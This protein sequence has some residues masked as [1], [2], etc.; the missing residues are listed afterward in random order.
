LTLLQKINNRFSGEFYIGFLIWTVSFFMPYLILGKGAYIR[1]HDTLEGELVWLHILKVSGYMHSIPNEVILQNLMHGLPRN[2]LP[3]GFTAIANLCWVFDIFY[4]YI[5]GQFIFKTIGYVSFYLFIKRY[6]TLNYINEYGIVFV[7]LL[8]MSI[9]FFTPFG[10]S[11]MGMPLLAYGFARLYYQQDFKITTAIFF[12][13]PFFSSFVWSG[14][15]III[16]FNIYIAYLFIIKHDSIKKWI[17]AWVAFIAG[18]ALANFQFIYGMLFL[19]GFRSHRVEYY[20]FQDVPNISQS[21]GDFFSFF[22]STHYHISIFVSTLIF[23]VFLI[24]HYGIKKN[25]WSKRLFYAI[26][27]IVLWQAFYNY[28]EYFTQQIVFIKSFRFNRF[29]FLLP[30]L[31]FLI[32]LISLDTIARYRL[33]SKSI[34]LILGSQF[35]ILFLANDETQH[36][37]RKMWGMKDEF[38]SYTEYL[39]ERQFKEIEKIIPK[40]TETKLISLGMSPTI[41]QYHDYATLDGLYSVYDLNYKYRFRQIMSA[42]LDKNQKIREKFDTWGNRCYLYSDELGVE[43]VQNCQSAHDRLKLRNLKINTAHLKS[44]G[45]TYLLSACEILNAKD[46]QLSFIKSVGT[47][48]DFWKIYIYKL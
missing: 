31:W 25:N 4:G 40:S 19:K 42:E 36:N 27:F 37:Y 34:P 10:I 21:L 22:F 12:I 20:Q 26:I 28:I 23:A 15:E 2:V 43:N 7:C 32:L 14:I 44:I 5:L 11:I 30:F 17:A 41:A 33:L 48:K 24:S 13:F 18:T 45:A 29:G 46:N 9:Q 47:E 3:S 38:P 1:I 8:L 16:L 35:L 39:A 6:M